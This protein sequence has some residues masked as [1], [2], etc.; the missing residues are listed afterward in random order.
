MKSWRPQTDPSTLWERTGERQ[1]R[2]TGLRVQRDNGDRSWC[3]QLWDGLCHPKGLRVT[4][5]SPC[6]HGTGYVTPKG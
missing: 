3:L 5:P 4:G 6:R 2:S 1:Q